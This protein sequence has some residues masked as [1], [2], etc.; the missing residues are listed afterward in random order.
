FYFQ[1]EDGIRDRNVTGVQTCALP[2]YHSL[3]PGQEGEDDGEHDDADRQSPPVRVDVTRR[4]AAVTLVDP[5]DHL[6][7]EHEPEHDRGDEGKHDLP[8]EAHLEG[9]YGVEVVAELAEL[10]Q[11]PP[12]GDDRD[13]ARAGDADVVREVVD[14]IEEV[15]ALGGGEQHDRGDGHDPADDSDGGV[16]GEV[17]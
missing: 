16:A 13:E 11:H 4:H 5:V 2:I 15:E 12:E 9:G 8:G 6:G 7:E 3:G 10:S 1:A 17:E 14:D